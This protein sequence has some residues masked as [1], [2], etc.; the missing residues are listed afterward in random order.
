MKQ[1]CNTKDKNGK[2]KHESLER[3][4]K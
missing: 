2:M 3:T 4:D 1:I